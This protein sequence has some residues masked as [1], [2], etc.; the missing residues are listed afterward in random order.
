MGATEASSKGQV[1]PSA[2]HT[3]HFW[4]RPLSQ[5]WKTG[6]G[7]ISL[8]KPR[9]PHE[10]LLCEPGF[11]HSAHLKTKMQYHSVPTAGGRGCSLCNYPQREAIVRSFPDGG[12][13]TFE[14]FRRFHFMGFFARWVL[15]LHEA[16]NVT[17]LFLI[18]IAWHTEGTENLGNWVSPATVLPPRL[19]TSVGE[20]Y[21]RW[22]FLHCR[23]IL[24]V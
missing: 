10:I 22:M 21:C 2:R 14:V 16:S 5:T 3:S 19:L 8:E 24:H 15:S 18:T 6:D 9:W 12:N 20:N 13:T 7:V 4:S 11:L 23:A 1:H 17:S